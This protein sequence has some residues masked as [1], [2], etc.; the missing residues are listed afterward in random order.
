MPR[1]SESKNVDVFSLP[2]RDRELLRV[3]RRIQRVAEAHETQYLVNGSTA[4]AAA[5]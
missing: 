5:N 2:Q 3:Y 1:G 4:S